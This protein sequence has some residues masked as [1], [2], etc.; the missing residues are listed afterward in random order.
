MVFKTLIDI[1]RAGN[2]K[3]YSNKLYVEIYCK[4]PAEKITSACKGYDGKTKKETR[5]EAIADFNKWIDYKLGMLHQS[6]AC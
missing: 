5:K 4:S 6:V 2:Y 1:K 3:V